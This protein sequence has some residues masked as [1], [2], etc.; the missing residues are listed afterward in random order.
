MRIGRNR[1]LGEIQAKS[2]SGGH[3]ESSRLVGGSSSI[4]QGPPR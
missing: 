3:F 1:R 4:W 2:R